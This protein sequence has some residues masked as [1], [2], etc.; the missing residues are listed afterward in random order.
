MYVSVLSVYLKVV[1][2]LWRSHFKIFRHLQRNSVLVNCH[3]PFL[4]AHSFLSQSLAVTRLSLVF[5][6]LPILNNQV[7]VI[8]KYRF[9]LLT[10]EMCFMCMCVYMC[11]HTY[12]FLMDVPY[13][14]PCSCP[15]ARIKNL[16]VQCWIEI[17]RSI[18]LAVFLI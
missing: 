1:L 2:P 17:M 10:C 8:I 3:S 12:I 7:N 14:F 15:N 5:I 6:V 18:I 16:P 9:L 13:I 11:V 4:P